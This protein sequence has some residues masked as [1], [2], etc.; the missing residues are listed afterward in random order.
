MIRK[1]CSTLHQILILNC[2]L[3]RKKKDIFFINLRKDKK[4]LLKNDKFSKIKFE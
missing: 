2:N 3:R 4:E 1:K